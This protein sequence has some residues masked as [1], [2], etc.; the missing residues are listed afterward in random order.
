MVTSFQCYIAM[1]YGLWTTNIEDLRTTTE[2]KTTSKK[3]SKYS[4]ITQVCFLTFS[5]TAQI[6][7]GNLKISEIIMYSR[8]LFYF[9]LQVNEETVIIYYMWLYCRATFAALELASS[10]DIKL[11]VKL[12]K[13]NIKSTFLN[14]NL[15]SRLYLNTNVLCIV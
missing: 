5:T 11:W 15:I 10:L 12:I 13:K 8:I 2:T 9:V 3:K 6:S 1:A 4:I 14:Q 7:I